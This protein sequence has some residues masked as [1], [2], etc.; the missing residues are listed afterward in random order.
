M[1][2]M[3]RLQKM[4]R[5]RRKT[6]IA[7]EIETTKAIREALAYAA[8]TKGAGLTHKNVYAALRE[9]GVLLRSYNR[10]SDYCRDHEAELWHSVASH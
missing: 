1:S 8:S 3:D 9:S 10:F 4:D 7:S 2:Y 5:G 6:G